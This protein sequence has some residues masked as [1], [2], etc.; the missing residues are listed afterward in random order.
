MRRRHR[1][2][3]DPRVAAV[4]VA[5]VLV[6]GGCTRR[7]ATRCVDTDGD[8]YGDARYETDDCPHIGGDCNDHD[9]SIHPGAF[10]GC[11]GLDT[12]CDGILAGD[13]RDDDGDGVTECDGDCDDTEATVYPGAPEICDGLDNDCDGDAGDEG[14][15]A[16]G[17]G[18][19]TCDGDCDDSNDAVHPGADDVCDDVEDNDCDGVVDPQETDADGDGYA[20]C[21]G[22]CDDE[23]PAMNPED[24]DGDGFSTCESDCDDTDDTLTPV[25]LD[26]D[27]Y[28]PCDGD[29]DENDPAVGPGATEICGDGIDNNCDGGDPGVP[30]GEIGF[31]LDGVFA[32]T[33]PEGSLPVDSEL[34]FYGNSGSAGTDTGS[35]LV[36]N[37]LV[38]VGAQQEYRNT[39]DAGLM[40]VVPFG[41]PASQIVPAGNPAPALMTAGDDCGTSGVWTDSTFSWDGADWHVAADLLVGTAAEDHQ[42]VVAIM[43]GT[44]ANACG[45]DMP[46]AQVKAAYTG[47]DDTVRFSVTGQGSIEIVSPGV[48]TWHT[49][50]MIH[51]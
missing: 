11:D 3:R 40:D 21:D 17:D 8:G 36:D 2:G 27:G 45:G 16:D 42:A 48:G 46:L 31:C 13:E 44:V 19:S 22:D 15:D 34:A 14:A 20:P 33:L 47:V 41:D 43:D 1:S 50:E 4:A 28:S 25:D 29:C 32:G 35:G 5:A 51:P 26:G 7:V 10:E 30:A 9:P 6:A 23:D 39:F 38:W 12:D 24:A 18:Y 37:V 49:V